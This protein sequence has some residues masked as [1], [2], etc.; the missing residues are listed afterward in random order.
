M[1]SNNTAKIK[2]HYVYDPLCGWCY[3]ASSL[4]QS[5]LQVEH[6]EVIPHAGGM[7]TGQNLRPV[8]SDF[9]EFVLPHTGRIT[10]LTGQVFGEGYINHLLRNNQVI[11]DSEPPIRAVLAVEKHLGVAQA[12]HMLALIQK[13]HYVLGQDITKPQAL[14][15]CAIE[16]GLDLTNYRQMYES[17]DAMPHI[18]QTRE[19]M[20]Q[21]GVGGFPTMLLEV[22][23][24][25]FQKINHTS[26]Y[27]KPFEFKQ[28]LE[29]F[30]LQH[31]VD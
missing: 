23:G 13:N 2:L 10:Q 16:L 4:I 9:R 24:K 20:G 3:G 1:T 30:V 31:M 17:T 26:Y 29:G 7:H 8:T 22:E 25:D 19:L 11:L 6:L 27:G 14:E 5:A 28:A 18:R 21:M 12:L 15:T